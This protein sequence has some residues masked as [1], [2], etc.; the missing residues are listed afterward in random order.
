[1]A[2]LLE[3]YSKSQMHSGKVRNRA[4]V[5]YPEG[6]F[7]ESEFI[8]SSVYLSLWSMG[9]LDELQSSCQNTYDFGLELVICASDQYSPF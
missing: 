9:L 2:F 1:M 8:C 7:C 3:H 5:R 6:R 4:E